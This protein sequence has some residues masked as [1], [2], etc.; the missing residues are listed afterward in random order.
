MLNWLR[1]Q[2]RRQPTKLEQPPQSPL[3][4]KRAPGSSTTRGATKTPL[5]LVKAHRRHINKIARA[6]RAANR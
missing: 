6:S 3:V 2:I 5:A 4:V 1:S